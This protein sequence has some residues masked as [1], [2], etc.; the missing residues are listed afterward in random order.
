MVCGHGKYEWKK[1]DIVQSENKSTC[2]VADLK[3]EPWCN[4]EDSSH[5]LSVKLTKLGGMLATDGL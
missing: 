2:S 5:I 4:K 1:N 3:P